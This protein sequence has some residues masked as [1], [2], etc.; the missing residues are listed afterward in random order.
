MPPA[1]VH[2][3]TFH[4]AMVAL[5]AIP[6]VVALL[7][8]RAPGALSRRIDHAR[9]IRDL[10]RDRAPGRRT[11]G[12]MPAL[13]FDPVGHV[14]TL[15]GVRV[16]SVTQILK[17]AGLIDFSSVP[18]PVLENARLRGTHVHQAIHYFNEHDLDVATF[19]REFPECAGYLEAWITFTERRRFEPVLNERRLA[20][21]KYQV[22]GT[23]D[24]FGFLDGAP[25]LLDFAT[26]RPQD[27]AKDL[28]T[29]AYYALA[30]EWA[31]DGADPELAVFLAQSRGALTRYGVALRVDGT[32][33]LEP[34]SNASDFREFLALVGAY[35]I[36]ANRRAA[37][38]EVTT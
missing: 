9:R 1:D 25:V 20:S 28:Q 7:C 6:R 10:G 30:L 21:R 37:L 5:T 19:D 38:A 36:V 22:A 23:A 4:D 18:P 34:Y 17:H 33:S 12:P 13:T 32:F 14:Y 31:G 3:S 35:R 24:C 27:V 11:D 8:Q 29:G 15:D 2:P 26:G 16:P